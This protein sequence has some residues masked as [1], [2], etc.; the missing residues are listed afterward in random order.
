MAAGIVMLVS[1]LHSMKQ[2]SPSLFTD[3]VRSTD[4]SL[5][6][7]LNPLAPIDRRFFGKVMLLSDVQS[8]K[9]LSPMVSRV[10]ASEIDWR[11]IQLSTT[12]SGRTFIPYGKFAVLSMES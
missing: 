11:D 12:L 8:K 7:C 1:D 4:T 9:Q 3:S 5:S 10:L 6:Q 2:R